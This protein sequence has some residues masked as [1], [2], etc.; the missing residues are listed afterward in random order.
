MINI[1]YR[2]SDN[3]YKKPKFTNATKIHCLENAAREFGQ[4]PFHLFID[5]TNL[6][7]STRHG[8]QRLLHDVPNMT[9]T[10]YVGG[11]SAQSF[12][13]VFEYALKTFNDDD[14]IF[15][16]EDDYLYLPGTAGIIEEGLTRSN[17]VTPYLHGDRFIPA[18]QGG[19]QFVDDTG[20]YVTRLCKTKTC[21]WTQVEST[22]MTFATTLSQLKQDCEIWRKYTNGTHPNDFALFLELGAQQRSLVAPIP[23]YATHAE[24]AWQAPLIGTGVSRWEDV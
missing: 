23:T 14:I 19:N 6:I 17:Y 13:Y 8:V 4:Y 24:P 21:F 5:E 7:D 18:S 10:S 11:S 9:I 1:I 12:R 2:I 16:S 20:A 15:F 3:G 22:T